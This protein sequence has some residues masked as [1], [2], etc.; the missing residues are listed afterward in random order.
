VYGDG[1]SHACS[2]GL[3]GLHGARHATAVNRER[4]VRWH[5]GVIG[6]TRVT[7]VIRVIRVSRISSVSRDY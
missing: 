5:L 2:K 3:D 7:R 4:D 1:S 6:V